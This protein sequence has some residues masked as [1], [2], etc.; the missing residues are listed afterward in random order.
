MVFQIRK[1]RLIE[2]DYLSKSTVNRSVSLSFNLALFPHP[3]IT[4]KTL[5]GEEP[6]RKKKNMLFLAKSPDH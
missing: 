1:L 4:E 2:S 5:R 3:R 6:R